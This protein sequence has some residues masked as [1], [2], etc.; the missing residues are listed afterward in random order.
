M[1]VYLVD[2]SSIARKMLHKSIASFEWDVQ[3]FGSGQEILDTIKE[4]RPDLVFMDLTM[5][6]MD[7]PELL[8]KIKAFDKSIP[9]I[10]ISAD[11]QKKMVELV[12]SLGAMDLIQKPIDKV[13]LSEFLTQ[14]GII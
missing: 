4:K 1:L 14:A 10:V 5:P 8:E 9:V 12:K 6:V 11:K 2:D 3:L 13:K 7:G